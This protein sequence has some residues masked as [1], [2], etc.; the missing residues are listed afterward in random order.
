M[1]N[2]LVNWF[3]TTTDKLLGDVDALGTSLHNI[4]DETPAESMTHVGTEKTKITIGARPGTN[5]QKT[6]NLNKMTKNELEEYGRT[7]GIELDRRKK[8]ATLIIEL[9]NHING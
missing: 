4:P 6:P 2:K 1:I 9:K 8:K 7:I 5:P 3:K